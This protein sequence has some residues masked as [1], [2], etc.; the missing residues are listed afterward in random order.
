[1]PPS[2]GPHCYYYEIE[3]GELKTLEIEDTNEVVK[4]NWDAN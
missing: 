2:Q 3:N 1:M 4:V